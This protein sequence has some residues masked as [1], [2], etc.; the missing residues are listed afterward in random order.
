[1]GGLLGTAVTIMLLYSGTH[2]VERLF[3]RFAT[4]EARAQIRPDDEPARLPGNRRP[5]SGGGDGAAALDA[6]DDLDEQ[7]SGDGHAGR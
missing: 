3:D 4:R 7:E 6:G 5:R 2:E 1:M